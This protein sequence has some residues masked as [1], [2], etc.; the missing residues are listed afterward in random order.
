[1]TVNTPVVTLGGIVLYDRSFSGTQ[2]RSHLTYFDDRSTPDND[3]TV[4]TPALRPVVL[5]YRVGRDCRE[6]GRGGAAYRG[7]DV[8][9]A[10]G[11]ERERRLA[12][13]D[14]GRP[15]LF[16]C[17]QGPSSTDCNLLEKNWQLIAI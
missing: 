12:I 2:A 7:R 9:W 4:N 10:V 14:F 1:M 15:L 3:T 5:N 11:T 8:D 16:V 17:L 13:S 6:G